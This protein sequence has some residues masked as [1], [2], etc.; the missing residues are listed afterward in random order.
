[1]TWNRYKNVQPTPP[2]WCGL[3]RSVRIPRV[4]IRPGDS[5]TAQLHD[6]DE[7]LYFPTNKN[8]SSNVQRR[9]IEM[10]NIHSKTKQ[11]DNILSSEP[12]WNTA[13]CRINFYWNQR[14]IFPVDRYFLSVL[15]W[16]CLPWFNLC[17]WQ[18]SYIVFLITQEWRCNRKIM[19]QLIHRI[20][21]F[22][23]AR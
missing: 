17:W 22:Y 1:M 8:R 15:I 5:R 7:P 16:P 12:F 11:F 6:D 21:V 4:E 19:I 2:G 9:L 10:I 14:P 18:G 20:V 23:K 3:M 13:G